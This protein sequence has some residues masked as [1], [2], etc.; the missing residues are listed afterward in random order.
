MNESSRSVKQSPFLDRVEA[1]MQRIGTG[2]FL[3]SDSRRLGEIL[4]DDQDRVH[5]LGLTHEDVANR[6]EA[7]GR[8]ARHRL[9]DS[10]EVEGRYEII[11]HE[12]RGVIPCPWTHPEGLFRKS[13]FELTD[14]KSGETLKWTDLSLHLV[15]EHGFYQG[16][17]SPYRLEPRIIKEV[18]FE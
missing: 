9:G 11:A 3:G 17:G 15:R 7:L 5:S 13:H 18:L 10:V 16:L 8:V 4:T 2:T 1:E 6:L 14:Q 12:S